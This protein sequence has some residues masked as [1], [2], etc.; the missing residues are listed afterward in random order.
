MVD[1]SGRVSSL[2]TNVLFLTQ[3]L[4]RKISIDSLSSY[5]TTWNQQF[6]V[7]EDKYVNIYNDLQELQ[8]LYSNLYLG[9]S[10]VNGSSSIVESFETISK[11]LKQYNSSYTYD[12]SY[13]SSIQY[14][15]TGSYYVRKNFTYNIDGL[16]T[17]VQLTGNP[18]PSV[19]LNKNFFYT[20][21]TLTGVTYT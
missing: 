11:N 3:D 7:L 4:L 10:G 2:E 20:G 14:T 5:S 21:T 16:L 19:S 15:I 17:S 8:N 6:D 1:L 13:L 18:I 12:G 9:I